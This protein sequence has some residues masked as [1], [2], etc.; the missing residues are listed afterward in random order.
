MTRIDWID[1]VVI[2]AGHAGLA[3]S[4][5]LRD[6]GREHVVLERGDIGGGLAP[7][8]VGLPE[9]PDARVDERAAGDGGRGRP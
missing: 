6:A 8:A 9:A 2:G 1:T 3:T 4:R 5:A 7:R